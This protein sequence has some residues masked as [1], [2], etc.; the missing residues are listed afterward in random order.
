MN[1]ACG[2]RQDEVSEFVADSFE[3]EALDRERL[4]KKLAYFLRHGLPYGPIS[5]GCEEINGFIQQLV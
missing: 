5:H 4:T 3:R 2:V 1:I